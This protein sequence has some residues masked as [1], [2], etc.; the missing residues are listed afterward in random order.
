MKTCCFSTAGTAGLLLT[1]V[2][3]AAQLI[4]N[5][6]KRKEPQLSHGAEQHVLTASLLLPVSAWVANSVLLLGAAGAGGTT[7]P[8]GLQNEG[9]VAKTAVL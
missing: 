4:S 3:V 7:S 8:K 9:L 1:P 6:H 2:P 5:G